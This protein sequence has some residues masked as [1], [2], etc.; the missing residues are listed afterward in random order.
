MS[1]KSADR[2]G[3]NI[4]RLLAWFFTG[5]VASLAIYGIVIGDWIGV[6]GFGIATLLGGGLIVWWYKEDARRKFDV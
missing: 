5:M 2:S 1:D 4:L 3:K 6:I